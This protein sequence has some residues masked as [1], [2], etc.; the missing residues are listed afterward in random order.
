MFNSDNQRNH[1][2]R[3]LG[4][5]LTLAA[6]MTVTILVSGPVALAQVTTP[7]WSN[8]GNLNTAR[9]G[10]T[11]TLL[12]N[13]KVLVAGGINWSDV[14]VTNTAELYDPATGKWSLT[15][16]LN[17]PRY[18][19]TATLLSNGNVLVAGGSVT[20]VTDTNTAEL[21]DPTTGAWSLTGNLNS[22]RFWHSATLLRNGNVLIVGGSD[23]SS[24]LNT[25][26]LYEPETG[27]WSVTG[28]LNACCG[29]FSH[30]ATLLQN[31]KVLVAGGTDDED[32]GPSLNLTSTELYDPNT[33]AWSITGSLNTGRMRHTATILP[34]GNVLA[35]GGMDFPC[36][37]G[38][39]YSTVNDTAEL[40]NP[41]TGTWRYTGRLSR[42]SDHTATLLPNGK[43][44]VAGGGDIAFDNNF[45]GT[46]LNSAELYDPTTGTWGP[47]ANLNTARFFHTATLLSNGK[48]LVVGVSYG[49]LRSTELYNAGANPISNPIDDAQFFVRQHYRDF[50]NR[51]PD[52]PGL[53][54]WTAEITAC[55]DPSQRQPGE[56][57]ELCAER[58]RANT[59]AAFFLS[60]EFQNTGTFVLRVYWG[61]LG[62]LPSAQCG[63]PGG[64]LG[65][66]RPLYNAYVADMSRVTSGIVVNNKLAPDVIN[67][68]KR[69]FID[70]FVN[71]PDFKASY[72]SLSNQQFVDKLFA[73]TAIAPTDAERST[74]VS[75]MNTGAETRSSVVFKV[76]DGTQT[77]TDGALIF[78]TRYGQAFY[79]QEFDAAFVFME[80]VG[81]LQRN[82]DQAGYEYWLGKLKLYGNWV[83]A[84]MVLS[85][86]LSPEYRLR[87]AQS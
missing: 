26:E 80:Y 28:S 47:T 23:E 64:L 29:R 16:S 66:C 25:A 3:L 20:G 73:T 75:G 21:Y 52:A 81:Y 62:K 61:T 54:H 56:S 13:G 68:N 31:G 27:A 71:T 18:L 70:Q 46:S 30:T 72:D 2:K 51:E 57:L 37:G 15:G 55:N 24:L 49:P 40:Y 74:L 45:Q 63:L 43:I 11:A 44:L 35:A 60:P 82:P 33:G 76:V 36:S 53:A 87:F 8:T 38:F 78:N 22:I 83:D 32:F 79:D 17:V 1:T 7:S 48:V 69:A 67:A 6:L 4:L 34:N 86:I 50:L 59:S 42:R 77:V 39:C 9:W 19:F 65:Q 12:P 14:T 41:V 5:T 58:K 10:H 85:F 84:E